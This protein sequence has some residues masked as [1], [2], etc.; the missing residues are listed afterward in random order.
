MTS[1]RI[2]GRPYHRHAGA[3][4]RR[5]FDEPV[6]RRGAIAGAVGGDDAAFGA[7][8]VVGGVL[9]AIIPE[10]EDSWS[11][12]AGNAVSDWAGGGTLGTVLGAGAAG[13]TNIVEAPVNLVDAGIGGVVNTIG[14][15]FDS[16]EGGRDDYWGQAKSWIGDTASGAWDT[17]TSWF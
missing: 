11:M 7:G 16:D 1:V 5:L 9:D 3:C 4:T 13:L 10:E 12:Q 14:N 6:C 2:T 17:V 8:D 15:M